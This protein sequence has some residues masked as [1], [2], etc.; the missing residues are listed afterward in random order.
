LSR[1]DGEFVN[2]LVIDGLNP[3]VLYAATQD[4]VYKSIDSA[5]TW[6]RLDLGTGLGSAETLALAIDPMSPNILYAGTG[7]HGLLKSTNG[8]A[9]WTPMNNGLNW[10]HVQSLAIDPTD[11]ST[12]YAE[13]SGLYK[14]TNGGVSWDRSG[15]ERGGDV[16]AID[17]SDSKTLYASGPDGLLKSTDAGITWTTLNLGVE[18]FEIRALA[19]NRSDTKVVYAGGF[20][21]V[22][23][24]AD[25]GR[26]WI[27]FSIDSIPRSVQV[28]VSEHMTN[29]IHAGTGSGSLYSLQLDSS[30]I[31]TDAFIRGKHLVVVGVHLQKKSILFVDNIKQKTVRDKENPNA[32]LGKKTG[33]RIAV[34]QQV[35]LQLQNPDGRLSREFAFTKP[36]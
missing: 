22:L 8:G 36:F 29:T 24:S 5:E 16:L 20:T 35:I 30:P 3:Q 17:P 9:D 1:G 34:G 28:L 33:K 10:R 13:A 6:V 18:N 2:Q 31:I 12:L 7:I 14:T 4:G 21:G 27:P 11:P 23:R 19:I 32:V 26:T 25:A 15:L